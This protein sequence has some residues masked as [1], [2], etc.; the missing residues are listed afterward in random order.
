MNRCSHVTSILLLTLR[1]QGDVLWMSQDGLD[2]DITEWRWAAV[3]GRLSPRGRSLPWLSDKAVA[4]E[5]TICHYVKL[6]RRIQKLHWWQQK[7]QLYIYQN[8]HIILSS[9]WKSVGFKTQQQLKW[10][11]S[12][13]YHPWKILLYDLYD[14]QIGLTLL[15]LRSNPLHI[16]CHV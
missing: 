12:A 10:T 1:V 8:V 5:I 13:W 16:S 9:I 3:W 4:Q 7:I 11:I 6:N 15:M 14:A 2:A